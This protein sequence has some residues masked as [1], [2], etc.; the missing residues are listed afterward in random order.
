VSVGA[1]VDWFSR[2]QLFCLGVFDGF[3]LSCDFCSWFT[4]GLC[5]SIFAEKNEDSE[6][7]A[8]FAN[9]TEAVKDKDY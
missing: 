7:F 5:H 3:C 2:S 4:D 8:I 6:K 1:F 9:K